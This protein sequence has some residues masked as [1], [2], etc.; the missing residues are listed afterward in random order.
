MSSP[1]A[2]ADLLARLRGSGRRWHGPPPELPALADR[3][4]EAWFS[5]VPRVRAA[6][7]VAGA[8]VLLLVTG[9]GAARSPWGPPV[10]VLVA[11]VD[12]TPG[13]AIGPEDVRVERRPAGLAP[14]DVVTGPS[15]VDGAHVAGTVV[16]GSVLTARHLAGADPVTAGLADGRVAYPV[17]AA[18]LP[19][20]QVGQ[21]LDLVASEFDGR[22]RT[23]ARD[24]RVIAVA[25]GTVWLD[26]AREDAAAIAGAAARD[27]LQVVLLPR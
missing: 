25:D 23:L 11:A 1:D 17:D 6:L 20:L 7:L 18:T 3:L 26:V 9:T 13:A 12:L 24:A 21:R 22:G 16:A 2:R 8:L 5:L 19:P 4:S 10:E 15:Q 27:G 14:D